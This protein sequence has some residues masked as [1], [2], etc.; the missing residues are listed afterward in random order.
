MRSPACPV[1]GRTCTRSLPIDRQVEPRMHKSREVSAR[2]RRARP[3]RTA[4]PSGPTRR[5]A[6]VQ[7]Y[8]LKRVTA[9]A[10]GTVSD[11]P[12]PVP[13]L[14]CVPLGGPGRFSFSFSGMVKGA[15]VTVGQESRTRL[16]RRR[17]ELGDHASWLLQPRWGTRGREVRSGCS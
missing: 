15:Y 14:T 6:M 10:G 9:S 2:P 4:Y 13:T 5:P 1:V 3:S 16:V 12:V 11:R 7:V 17:T 8:V